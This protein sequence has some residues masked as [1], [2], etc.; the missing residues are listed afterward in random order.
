MS[1]SCVVLGTGK[2]IAV[3]LRN[4]DHCS[5]ESP[6]QRSSSKQVDLKLYILI[7]LYE[8]IRLFLGIYVYPY[9]Y[10]NHGKRGYES[11]GDQGREYGRV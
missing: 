6:G 9:V 10:N 8:P 1:N 5:Q 11:E 4:G 2:K 3:Y 7:T